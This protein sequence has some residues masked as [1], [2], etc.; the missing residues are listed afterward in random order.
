MYEM[1]LIAP[2]KCFK[3]LD[4]ATVW[5]Q[6]KLGDIA[7]FNPK[8]TV[9]SEFEYVDLASVKGITMLSHRTEKR[10]S[11]PSRAQRLARP[12]DIFYA[13]V[14]PHQ[15]NNYLY[16]LPYSNYV[17]STGYVQLRPSIDSYFLFSLLQND[18]FV[19]VVVDNCAGSCYPAISP[20]ALRNIEVRVPVDI[21]LQIKIGQFFKT[22]DELITAQQRN[23]EKM[24]LLKEAYL[25]AMFPANGENKP[26]R[27]FCGFSDFWKNQRLG[28]ICDIVGGGTP[29]TNVQN[30]WDGDINWFAQSDI[31]DQIYLY[32]SKKKITQLG[33]KESATKIL[34]VGTVLFA[35]VGAGL[36][37]MAILAKSGATNQG[38][39]SIVVHDNCLDP[40]FIFSRKNDL[41]KF[42]ESTAS[43]TTFPE[44]LGKQL[45]LMPIFIPS[46]DE[47][48]KIGHLFATLD[49]L[50]TTQQCCLGKLQNLKNSYLNELFA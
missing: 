17:F 29:R 39:Q 21:N 45:L 42:A 15:K 48:R 50:I 23:L 28:T 22:L 8:T 11:A 19:K 26:K 46:L 7:E 14:V 47:Q 35:S 18:R 40:Y 41:I 1:S 16:N 13:T 25:F 38:F 5:K 37:N 4:N 12:G 10:E 31:R 27:R 6:Q 30:Y 2:L 44:I 49:N 24:L 3:Q 9:P 32:E 36:G 43:S 20:N 33:L 34:P